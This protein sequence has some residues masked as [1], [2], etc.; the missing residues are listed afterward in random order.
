M[1]QV[2]LS[3]HAKKTIEKATLAYDRFLEE[4]RMLR[5]ERIRLYERA[6]KEIESARTDRLRK[7]ISVSL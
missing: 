1:A 7:K 2:T 3:P 4:L 5:E 6:M